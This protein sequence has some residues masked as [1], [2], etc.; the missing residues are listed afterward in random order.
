MR[1]A[2]A[3]GQN[4]PGTAQ[5]STATFPTTSLLEAK[6]LHKTAAL[7]CQRILGETAYPKMPAFLIIYTL[8]FKI[9]F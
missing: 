4:A 6:V 9:A 2:G 8:S 5:Q 7:Q 1:R 3:E